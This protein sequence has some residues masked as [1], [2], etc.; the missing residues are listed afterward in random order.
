MSLDSL[1]LQAMFGECNLCKSKSR[2]SDEKQ[3]LVSEIFKEIF[4]DTL[5]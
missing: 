4:N 2:E 1:R 5:D 3:L